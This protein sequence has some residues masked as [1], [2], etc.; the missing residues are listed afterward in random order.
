MFHV[1]HIAPHILLI[2]PWITDFAAY[3]FWIKPLGLLRIASLLRMNGFRI[4]LIDCTDYPAKTKRY[5]DGTFLKSKIE[6]PL[7]LKSIPRN[8]S[9][10]GIPEEILLKRFSMLEE[11]P[12]LIGIASGMTYWYP[13]VFKAIEIAKKVFSNVPI[14]LGGIYATLCPEHA[15]KHSGADIVFEGSDESEVLKLISK[16]TGFETGL[17]NFRNP[18]STMRI[19]P[20][21]TCILNS[22]MWLSRPQGGAH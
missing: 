19:I 7:P 20:P 4:T 10:Y 21:L 17:C 18:Q 5:G 1:K 6:K 22:T 16:L 3:N 11:K 9:Q 13:G 12:D 15:R 14:I 8:F 2:N